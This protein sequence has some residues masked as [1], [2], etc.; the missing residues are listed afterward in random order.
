MSSYVQGCPV[1]YNSSKEDSTEGLLK[2]GKYESVGQSFWLSFVISDATVKKEFASNP[3]ISQVLK[4]TL[5][6]RRNE[7]RRAPKR[8]TGI[9]SAAQYPIAFSR[10]LPSQQRKSA[11]YQ[12]NEPDGRLQQPWFGRNRARRNVQFD[13]SSS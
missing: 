3:L 7:A 11:L 13:A 9:Y 8:V 1:F 2:S 4:F 10:P 12:T 5:S 6:S